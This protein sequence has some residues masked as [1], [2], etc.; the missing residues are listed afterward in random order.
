VVDV[1]PIHVQ[2][3]GPA[4]GPRKL[5]FDRSPVTFGRAPE[6]DIVIADTA[7]SRQH[8]ELQFIDGAWH[9]TNL[10]VNGTRVNGKRVTRKPRQLQSGDLIA[11]EDVPLF[12]V[13]LGDAAVA[14]TDDTNVEAEA[15]ATSASM[16]KRTKLY[17]GLGAYLVLMLVVM[18]IGLATR[19]S[20]QRSVDF[21]P[22]L[23]DRE[24]EKEIIRPI[25][26][27]V[28]NPQLARQRLLE[29]KELVNRLESA[30]DAL[31]QAHRAFK[32]SL[33]YSGRDKFAEGLDDQLFLQTQDQLVQEVTRRYRDA[34]A[35]LKA[36]SYP[37]A[38]RAFADL[39]RFY[40]DTRSI[41]FR[42]AEEQQAAIRRL[43]RRR[44]RDL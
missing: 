41:I 6:S 18:A 21:P 11:V 8:G 13:T 9:L 1:T 24:I 26:D 3:L 27:V 31:Y 23:T 14:T 5:S 44:D 25:T 20:G 37:E 2:L 17:I 32:E 28:E 40:S 29:A 30:P 7:V 4:A 22:M 38:E 36:R 16:A 12:K 33:A 19:G 42:N 34:Y 35:L 43:T 15:A 10:S 39:R